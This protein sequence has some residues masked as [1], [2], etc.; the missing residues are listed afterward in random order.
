MSV[1][2]R[3]QTWSYRAPPPR[4]FGP[5]GHDYERAQEDEAR[6][7]PSP[8]TLSAP[9]LRPFCT[10]CTG[11]GFSPGAHSYRL[12]AHGHSP[13]AYGC[14]RHWTRRTSL[15][16]TSSLPTVC[17]IRSHAASSRRAAASL[18]ATYRPTYLL[19]YSPTHRLASLLT[20][21]PL[22]HR[23]LATHRPLNTHRPLTTTAPLHHRR[24]AAW[25]SC[26]EITASSSMTSSR[27]GVPTAA[28][29]PRTT[30][31]RATATP[32][33]RAPRSTRRGCTHPAPRTP[34]SA[35]PRPAL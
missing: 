13:G 19:T 15:A 22:T 10:L 6:S 34:H 12:G 11:R 25:R 30:A 28:S 18:L 35:P 8:C 17:S 20:R 21:H 33:L 7:A 24:T 3:T 32:L 29:S 27:G 4:D 23:P 9:S 1:R 26:V 2:D 14:R 31:S 16:S 5:K